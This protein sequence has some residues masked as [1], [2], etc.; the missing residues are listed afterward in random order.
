MNINNNNKGCIIMK[1]TKET[2]S[3]A[4][5][6]LNRFVHYRDV[7]NRGSCLRNCNSLLSRRIDKANYYEKLR[8]Q[9]Q[10]YIVI[11]LLKLIFS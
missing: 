8:D 11:A 9:P 5:N 3:V 6:F 4:F 1:L 2:A 7:Y 10:N